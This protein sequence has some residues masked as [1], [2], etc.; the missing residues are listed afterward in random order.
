MTNPPTFLTD[1]LFVVA[2]IPDKD[3]GNE[4]EYYYWPTIFTDKVDA[5]G[6]IRKNQD[7]LL[8]WKDRSPGK[9]EVVTLTDVFD[10]Y[11][12]FEGKLTIT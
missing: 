10:G 4:D 6:F 7:N 8:D 1:N 11:S 9:L 12:S 5:E 2:Y 3:E